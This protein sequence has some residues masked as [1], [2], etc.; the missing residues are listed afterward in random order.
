MIK[1]ARVYNGEN[2]VSS[3]IGAEKTGQLQV[4]NKIRMF[5]NII[6]KNKLKMD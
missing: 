4:K 5:S 2:T 1:K 6:Y 3:V